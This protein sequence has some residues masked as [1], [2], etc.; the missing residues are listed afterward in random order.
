MPL[1]VPTVGRIVY[2]VAYKEPTPEGRAIIRPAII[3]EVH[4]DECVSLEIFGD[5]SCPYRSSVMHSDGGTNLHTWHWMPFQKGQAAKTE[6]AEKKAETL[7]D[8]L[9]PAAR[10][11]ITITKEQIDALLAAAVYT[12]TKMGDKTTVVHATLPNGF[13]LVET[14]G[15]VDPKNYNHDLGVAVCKRRLVDKVWLLEGYR[16]QSALARIGAL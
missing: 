9:Y 14:S 10:S 3:V 12:H 8:Q 6:E 16:L 7:A 1:I 5:P 15:C 13:E 2:F 11:T 4:S